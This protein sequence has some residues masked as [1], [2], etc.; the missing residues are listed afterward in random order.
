[1]ILFLDTETTGI[2]P[3]QI[4]QLSYIMQEKNSVQAKNFF[5]S[6]D[7]M[8]YG[9]FMVH[10]FSIEKLRE[11]S[12]GKVFSDDLNEITKDFDRADVL[13]AHNASFD[14]M[15]LRAEFE[16][17]GEVFAPKKEFCTMK[18]LTPICKLMR[19]SRVAYKYPKLSEACEFFGISDTEIK[20]DV[21]RLF[22]ENLGYHDARFDTTALY[23]VANYGMDK[24]LEEL[25]NYL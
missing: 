1:M 16:R 22:G 19:S 4:C 15:F 21:N 10:G 3:G 11:L 13:V 7:K 25:K 24:G 5:F 9:A 17:L 8:D 14:M 18:K 2:R 23:L 6:V 12:G 20:Q